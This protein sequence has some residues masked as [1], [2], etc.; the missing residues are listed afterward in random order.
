MHQNLTFAVHPDPISGMHCWHQAVRVRPASPHDQ[1]GDIAVDTGQARAVY[2]EWLRLTRP[3]GPASP[4]GLR[5][6]PWL[7]R[8]LKPAASTYRVPG[9]VTASPVPPPAGPAR[10]RRRPG[11]AARARRRRDQPAAALPPGDREPRAARADRRRAHRRVRPRRAT[12][13]R[14]PPRPGG[15]SSAA[16]DWTGW[17]GSGGRSACTRR[18][19]PTTSARCSCCTPNSATRRRPHAMRATRDRLRHAREALL[20]EHLWSWAPGYLTAVIRLDVPS[21]AAWAR[22]TRSGPRPGSA[23]GRAAGRPSPG[24]AHRPAAGSDGRRRPGQLLD[25]AG[26][27]GALRR[28]ADRR[29]PARGRRGGRPRL[30]RRRAAVH[31][32]GPARPG[33][34][35]HAGL[36]GQPRPPVG[37]PA[38]RPA[39]HRRARS[40]A[41]VG[42]ARRPHGRHPGA[43]ANVA[44]PQPVKPD[45]R[46]PPVVLSGHRRTD[47]GGPRCAARLVCHRC[48]KITWTGCSA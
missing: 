1:H 10:G 42:A 45:V 43:A 19:T 37:G 41:L 14:D 40:P 36:A 8:P 34:R 13:R 39:A 6:P 46:I 47:H 2:Q 9:P 15:A 3:A 29:G 23:P 32:A 4:G 27:A 35:R 44:G 7:M 24:A 33:R 31:A 5:R 17:P 25:R 48:K 12:A 38:R 16:R 26:R 11:T 30:P 18:R 21:L 20:F 28:P 22:L